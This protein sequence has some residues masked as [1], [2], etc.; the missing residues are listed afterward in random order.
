[1]GGGD[2]GKKFHWSQN[3]PLRQKWPT[4]W[5]FKHEIKLWTQFYSLNSVKIDEKLI[6][7]IFWDKSPWVGGNKVWSKKGEEC[8]MGRRPGKNIYFSAIWA[9]FPSRMADFP[10]VFLYYFP[11]NHN[12]S[13]EGASLLPGFFQQWWGD[14]LFFPLMGGHSQSPSKKPWCKNKNTQ[15]FSICMYRVGPFNIWK[16]TKQTKICKAWKITHMKITLFTVLHILAKS[17]T[18]LVMYRRCILFKYLQCSR[19][20]GAKFV[21]SGNCLYSLP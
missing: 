19:K 4:F 7:Q 2:F 18:I 1:M 13:R 20:Y 16:Q 3:C 6:F 10:Y 14:W 17:S 12:I 8:Q 11:Q 9:K 15:T 21:C 5:C